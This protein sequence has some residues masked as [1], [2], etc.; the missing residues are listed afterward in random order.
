MKVFKI[1]I[2]SLFFLLLL[3]GIKVYAQGEC[4]TGWVQI[5]LPSVEVIV[6]GDTCDYQIWLCVHCEATPNIQ[7]L[8]IKI[9]CTGPVDNNCILDIADIHQEIEKMITDPEWIDENLV[10]CFVGVPPCSQPEWDYLKL[11]G[12]VPVCWKKY[13][14]WDGQESH[15]IYEGCSN[16]TCVTKYK[17]CWDGVKEIFDKQLYEGPYIEGSGS[18]HK[19][20]QPDP[21]PGQYSSCFYIEGD[22]WQPPE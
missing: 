10:E 3:S 15:I 1:F 5:Y 21:P 18:C 14:L 4:D 9:H 19:D 7:P 16:M 17:V 8:E 11:I 20:E 13:N 6:D 2:V 12:R 22:C